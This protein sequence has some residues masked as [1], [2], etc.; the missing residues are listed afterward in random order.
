MA[1]ESSG[2]NFLSFVVGGLVVVVVILFFALGG[3]DLF[4]GGK[5]DINVHVDLPE[6]PSSQ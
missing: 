5:S 1:E 3:V 6:A 2:T 4:R